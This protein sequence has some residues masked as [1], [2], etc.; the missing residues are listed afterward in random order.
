MPIGGSNIG[1]DN[2]TPADTESAGQGDDR[3]RSMKTSVQQALDNEHNFPAG[4]GA[5]TGYHRQGS[6]RAYYGT[7]SQV[8][9]TT[10]GRL[11]VTSDSSRLF[12][13]NS[14]GT[15][16]LGGQNVLSAGSS[17][18]GGQRFYWATEF[19][20]AVSDAAGLARV[21]IPNSG[22]SGVPFTVV[23]MRFAGNNGSTAQ[24]ITISATS[25]HIGAF[26]GS[27][28]SLNNAALDWISIGTRTF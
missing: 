19:G 6:A 18:V 1:W 20:Q 5:N 17:P 14:N 16:F 7:Q 23:G 15:L 3:I 26:N 24:I 13:V 22:F 4:G 12:A 11:M 25:F 8:S 28:A 9:A 27:A 21:D 10:D 2:A